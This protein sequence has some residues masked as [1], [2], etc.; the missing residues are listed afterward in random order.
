MNGLMAGFSLIAGLIFSGMMIAIYPEN[1]TNNA[2]FFNIITFIIGVFSAELKNKKKRR[3]SS[4][5]NV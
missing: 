4:E 5:D 2:Y 3:S 1:A